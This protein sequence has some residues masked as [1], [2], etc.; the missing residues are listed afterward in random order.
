MA[1][2]TKDKQQDAPVVSFVERHGMTITDD[3]KF[4]VA[5]DVLTS[6]YGELVTSGRTLATKLEGVAVASITMA[7]HMATLRS[8]TLKANDKPDWEGGT[9][10][11]KQALS[12]ALDAAVANVKV[13]DTVDKTN[14]DA[15]AKYRRGVRNDLANRTRQSL[16]RDAVLESM[17]AE[18]AAKTLDA[19]TLAAVK[20]G[21][22]KLGVALPIGQIP[23]PMIEAVTA[24]YNDNP[25]LSLPDRYKTPEKREADRKAKGAGS[26][27]P[28]NG[29]PKSPAEAVPTVVNAIANTG[30]AGGL[31]A[32]ESCEA[33][34]RM[35]TAAYDHWTSKE[36]RFGEQGR[37]AVVAYAERWHVLTAGLVAALTGQ[38]VDRDAVAAAR[39]TA[40]K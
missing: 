34:T 24:I 9:D 32:E 18:A 20:W 10:T 14:E 33:V 21:E 36:P 35:L 27:G 38:D 26:S 8:V 19:E 2:S 17:I 23:A 25:T 3:S 29:Q 12:A 1:P 4:A 31:A 39:W 7:R 30:H 5:D 28:G 6:L 15:V 22:F 37:D 16:N 40:N 13:P 11:Y